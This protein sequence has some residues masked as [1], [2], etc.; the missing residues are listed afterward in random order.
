MNTVVI[1][2]KRVKV[3]I[4]NPLGQGGEAYILDLGN[5]TVLK[6][7]R[8]P[9]DPMYHGDGNAQ[10]GAK[11]RLKLVREKLT[12]FPKLPSNV[13]APIELATDTAGNVVGYTMSKVTNA[14]AMA[15]Y[16]QPAFRSHVEG[17][18]VVDVL[19]KLLVTVA[20]VHKAG[21]IIGDF[22]SQN[23]LVHP[24]GSGSDVKVS[25]ID[26]DSFQFG[27]WKCATYTTAYGDPLNCVADTHSGA[28]VL[29]KPHSADS[30][31]YAYYVMACEALLAVNPYGGVYA[32]KGVKVN[33]VA[34]PMK[35]LTVWHADTRYPRP[36]E[37]WRGTLPDDV[38]QQFLLVFQQDLRQSFPT[39]LLDQ[40]RYTKC[41]CGLEHARAQCPKPGC[42]TAA[43]AVK[44][45]TTTTQVRGSVTATTV[46]RR[47][48][49]VRVEVHGGK[50]RWLSHHD[51][52]FRREGGDVVLNGKHNKSLRFRISTDA[53]Y[54]ALGSS[55][56]KLGTASRKF[57]VRTTGNVPVFAVNDKHVYWCED[58][59][60]YRDGGNSA[61]QK[62]T[63]VRIGNVIG[64]QTRFWVGD[65][66]GFGFGQA[67]GIT[68]AFVFDAELQGVND[69]VKLRVKGTLRDATCTIAGSRAWFF[70]HTQEG[71]R[72]VNRCVVVAS[73]GA[74]E[75]EAE[76]DVGD[77][78]LGSI[79][80]ACAA[81]L[82][83]LVPTDAGIMKIEVVSGALTVTKTFPDTEPFVDAGCQ[84]LA[85][86]DGL[87]VVAADRKEITR[88]V[89]R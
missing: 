27:Q 71:A 11:K 34:R 70:T 80:G 12:A 50:L 87:Y 84:L 45:V 88:L 66:F 14:E 20:N 33:H 89:I 2:G 8:A 29:T 31:D 5:N 39:K 77:G 22:N 54:A 46:F 81:G 30:D 51:N 67:G 53:T 36:S 69:G 21:V 32:P 78:W 79:R 55:V 64:G 48:H 68:V 28:P 25:L 19:R 72:T 60:L 82:A 6:L 1:A 9:S 17:N 15:R 75:A 83:L 38:M 44:P 49:V 24:G 59:A 52:A 35:R 37:P 3:D 42:A 85:A 43:P 61:F 4:D 47:G 26:A 13:I 57:N 23:V 76:A 65:K 16:G 56:V 73:N 40:V 7:Y 10:E 63:S 86:S 74:V 58:D 18:V 41:S 62:D